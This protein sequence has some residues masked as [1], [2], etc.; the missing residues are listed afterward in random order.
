M[1]LFFIVFFY[2]IL[3]FKVYPQS[4]NDSDLIQLSNDFQK[5]FNDRGWRLNIPLSGSGLI[6]DEGPTF[7]RV[8][9][10]V[11]W[12]KDDYR[13]I[14][15]FITNNEQVQD[16]IIYMILGV[17]DSLSNIQ[18]VD[19]YEYDHLKNASQSIFPN[20]GISAEF[21][22]GN[23]KFCDSFIVY[24]KS[25]EEIPNEFI[26]QFSLFFEYNRSNTEMTTH[27]D[28]SWLNKQLDIF[29]AQN[30][31][32]YSPGIR[33]GHPIHSRHEYSVNKIGDEITVKNI[34][35]GESFF[36]YKDSLVLYFIEPISTE[37][38]PEG[39]MTFVFDKKWSE[40][41]FL[42]SADIARISLELNNS[43][44]VDVLKRFRNN[45]YV[46]PFSTV[47]NLYIERL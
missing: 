34:D 36:L 14:N 35:Y 22:G 40:E 7:Y 41:E 8:N 45:S 9:D 37:K 31:I 21:F 20:P 11:Y 13:L 1:K 5:F 19:V 33:F 27:S 17:N 2:F 44:L 43:K 46:T 47:Y 42:A 24:L 16:S 30:P 3:L 10:S 29:L 15:K 38:R 4:A 6:F 23:R 32:K 12:G 18:I 26:A 25:L 28:N 39:K